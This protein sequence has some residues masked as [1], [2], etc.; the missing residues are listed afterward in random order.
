MITA[1][2][3]FDVPGDGLFELGVWSALHSIRSFVKPFLQEKEKKIVMIILPLQVRSQNIYDP[4]FH[5]ARVFLR[6][7]Y[8][9]LMQVVQ[10]VVTCLGCCRSSTTSPWP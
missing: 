8:S 1:G 5:K 2:D 10:V 7:G 6:C 3:F 9:A 4:P